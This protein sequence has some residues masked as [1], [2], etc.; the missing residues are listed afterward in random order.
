MSE[1]NEYKRT[2]RIGSTKITTHIPEDDPVFKGV[3]RAVEIEGGELPE[4]VG[5]LVIRPDTVE[6]AKKDHFVGGNCRQTDRG[7]SIINI[8]AGSIKEVVDSYLVDLRATNVTLHEIGHSERGKEIQEGAWL[9]EQPTE[10]WEEEDAENYVKQAHDRFQ[11]RQAKK[12]ASQPR[13][14]WRQLLESKKQT[15][16][17]K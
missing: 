12:R 6:S 4:H 10:K 17:D 5:R 14:T 8:F 11:E 15:S 16:T 1:R 9:G 2:F 3:M 13:L 7:G